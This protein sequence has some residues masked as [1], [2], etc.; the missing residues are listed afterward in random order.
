MKFLCFGEKKN[1]QANVSS[2]TSTASIS[3]SK[4]EELADFLVSLDL[5]DLRAIFE[6][7]RVTMKKLR[8][9]SESDLKELGIPVAD[10]RLIQ[11]E[12]P[13]FKVSFSSALDNYL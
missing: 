2:S 10:I 13:K 5:T 6:K 11:S 8:L 7:H 1:A 3:S 4:D 12:L 9:L